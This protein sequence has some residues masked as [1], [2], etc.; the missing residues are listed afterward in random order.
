MLGVFIKFTPKKII[1]TFDFKAK[2]KW[3]DGYFE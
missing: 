3:K 1:I 2:V